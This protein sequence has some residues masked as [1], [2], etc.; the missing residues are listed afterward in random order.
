MLRLE[1][2]DPAWWAHLATCHET[3]GF[4]SARA[5][6]FR[7]PCCLLSPHGLACMSPCDYVRNR[8][9][10]PPSRSSFWAPVR[11]TPAA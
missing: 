6:H 1:G 9:M 10:D 8:I 2:H 7:S 11:T 5:Q 3:F 4:A